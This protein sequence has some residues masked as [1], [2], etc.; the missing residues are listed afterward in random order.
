MCGGKGLAAFA[1]ATDAAN[2]TGALAAATLL[3]AAAAIAATGTATA[4][5]LALDD[6]A[7]KPTCGL[8]A[9]A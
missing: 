3:L 6:A 7:A 2:A 5:E 4:C 8:P 9:H 1:G